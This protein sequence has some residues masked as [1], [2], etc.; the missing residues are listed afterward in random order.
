MKSQTKQKLKNLNLFWVFQGTPLWLPSREMEWTTSLE[1][2]VHPCRYHH[3]GDH[4]DEG[5]YDDDGDHHDDDDGS[6]GD[7][8]KMMIKSLL[9]NLFPQRESDL[10]KVDAAD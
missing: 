10:A 6:S 8:M 9:Q 4:D 1:A 3:H 7:M 5:D 2:T